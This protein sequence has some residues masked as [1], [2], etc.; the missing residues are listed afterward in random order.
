LSSFLYSDMKGYWGRADA[1]L[2]NPF[3]TREY[4]AFFPFGTTWLDAAVK[5]AFARN[6]LTPIATLYAI[7]GASTVAA[8]YAIGH[9]VLRG[10]AP[11]PGRRQPARG[12]PRWRPGVRGVARRSARRPTPAAG[13]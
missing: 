10:W 8:A 2:D 9:R 7:F 3:S 5:P 4:E 13:G 6:A 11:P 1:M 12:S